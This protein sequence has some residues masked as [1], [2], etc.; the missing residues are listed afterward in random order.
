MKKTNISAFT[1]K[2]SILKREFYFLI[3]FFNDKSNAFQ[4][5][6]ME[7]MV[8]FLAFKMFWKLCVCTYVCDNP[9]KWKDRNY[10]L[11][12][13]WGNTHFVGNHF[14]KNHKDDHKISGR[15]LHSVVNTYRILTLYQ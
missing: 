4:K 15:S 3:F 9:E 6:R 1:Q 7:N 13:F 5:L 2:K 11:F 10:F 14:I 8:F 12:F